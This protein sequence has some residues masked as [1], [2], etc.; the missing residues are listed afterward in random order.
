MEK[1][2]KCK[3]IY[4]LVKRGMTYYKM[5]MKKNEKTKMKKMKMK[6][7]EKNEKTKI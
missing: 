6:K 4:P 5:K 3:M 2:K 1:E 7:N